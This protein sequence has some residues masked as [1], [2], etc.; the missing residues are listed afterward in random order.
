MTECAM[1]Y[2]VV[3]AAAALPALLSSCMATGDSSAPADK[4]GKVREPAQHLYKTVGNHKLV[5]K[6]YTPI[7][8]A[9]G[10]AR[11]AIV[12]FFGGGFVGGNLAHAAEYR[13]KTRPGSTP[14][15]SCVDGRSAVRRVRAHA[16][17]LGID[18]NRIAAGGGSAGGTVAA[19]AGRFH[20]PPVSDI[21]QCALARLQPEGDRHRAAA[22]PPP[23]AADARSRGLRRRS[24]ALP[25]GSRRRPAG[26]PR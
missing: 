23:T 13:V 2:G 17:D 16:G 24:W 25:P 21:R 10:N 15:D 12:F 18:P 11:P 7:D 8:G 1:A 19:M 14:V 20:C 5:L 3:F 9:A 26:R 4:A 22:R 6:V